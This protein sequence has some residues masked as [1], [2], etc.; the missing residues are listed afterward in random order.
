[1]QL[2]AGNPGHT[3][4]LVGQR[5]YHPNLQ[6]P[7]LTFHYTRWL[8]GIAKMVCEKAA[9][10][11]N[12]PGYHPRAFSP[13]KRSFNHH[14]LIQKWWRFAT[15]STGLISF[16]LMVTRQ[17]TPRFSNSD[18]PGSG[19][20]FLLDLF[21]LDMYGNRQPPQKCEHVRF[22]GNSMIY[23]AQMISSSTRFWQS[24]FFCMPT[25]YPSLSGQVQGSRWEMFMLAHHMIQQMAS[26]R[27]TVE[28]L[29]TSRV[30][31]TWHW[32]D[33]TICFWYL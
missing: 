33:Y 14:I 9:C 22:W 1:M 24:V 5:V 7:W 11:T 18:P 25:A 26:T 27:Q 8:R 20:Y 21:P 19:W 12:S 2:D 23:Q 10:G 32:L 17:D 29:N 6:N 30:S 13:T 4:F 15:T 3:E 31:M 16:K 28:F